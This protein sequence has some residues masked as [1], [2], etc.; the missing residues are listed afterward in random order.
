MNMPK[1]RMTIRPDHI[2]SNRPNRRV[3]LWELGDVKT[4]STL[5]GLQVHYLNALAD[6][7]KMLALR[8]EV[9][10]AARASGVGGGA[11]G[12]GYIIVTEH[13]GS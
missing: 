7:E 2:Q 11:G 12:S 5:H 1:G 10:T 4:G 6:V 3:R 8:V 13:Y 9:E